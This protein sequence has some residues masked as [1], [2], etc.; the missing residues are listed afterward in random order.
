MSPLKTAVSV[1]MPKFEVLEN[2]V[3]GEPRR[4]RQSPTF[5]AGRGVECRN[6]RCRCPAGQLACSKHCRLQ[7]AASRSRTPNKSGPLSVVQLILNG[8]C[9]VW[10]LQ[11]VLRCLTKNDED[12][13]GVV[14]ASSILSALQYFG[15]PLELWPFGL[16]VKH[17][18]LSEVEPQLQS[19]FP[20]AKGLLDHMCTSIAIGMATAEL[21]KHGIRS[22]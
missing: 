5:Y 7:G 12:I 20:V 15:I 14:D 22:A 6:E 3:R 21:A 17:D 4:P 13:T 10:C 11:E 9:G 2:C 18:V 1:G 8:C 16:K 19:D